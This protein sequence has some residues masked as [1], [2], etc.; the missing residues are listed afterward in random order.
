MSVSRVVMNLLVWLLVALP[1]MAQGYGGL[2]TSAGGFAVP[3]RATVLRFPEDH[4]PHRAFRI[5]W[6]YLTANLEGEDGADYGIQWTLF[7]SALVPE[8]GPGWQDRQVWMGHAALTSATV[9]RAAER[10]ARSGVGHAG[11][12]AEPFSAWIDDWEMT[13]VGTAGRDAL[14]DVVVKASGEGFGYALR[15]T[16]QGPLVLHGERGYSVKSAEG[17]ASHYYSQPFYRITGTI[18][19]DGRV[20][21]VTG[22]G[23]LDREWSSQPLSASQTGWDWF[24]LHFESGEK[25]MGFR[26][27]DPA[28]D[29]ISGSWIGARGDVEALASGA[30]RLTPLETAQVAGR[31]MPIRWRVELPAKGLDVETQP[32]NPQAWMALTFPYW[33]GPIRMSGS[34]GGVGYLEMTGYE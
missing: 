11:V 7:R 26:L 6:W 29:F 32:L 28:G 19:L 10:F 4:G 17:Q 27:R 3:S 2:G 20:L 31:T 24:S 8:E 15:A 25:L 9:H 30:L 34:H 23:W 18:T 33:E 14:D 5:E 21:S 22:Q 1:A 12:T 13:A 16:A